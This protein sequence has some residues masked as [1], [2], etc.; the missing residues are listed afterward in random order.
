MELLR[1]AADRRLCD[2]RCVGVRTQKAERQHR[3]SQKHLIGGTGRCHP[4]VA[5][6]ELAKPLRHRPRPHSGHDASGRSPVRAYPQFGQR[7][8]P[9]VPRRIRAAITP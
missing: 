2:G 3:S 6:G 1:A 4:A 8:R 7:D 5:F 9:A